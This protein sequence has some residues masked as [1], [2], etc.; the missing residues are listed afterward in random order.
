MNNYSRFYTVAPLLA[1]AK[2][3]EMEATEKKPWMAQGDFETITPLT[4]EYFRWI[5]LNA[6]RL[7]K[8]RKI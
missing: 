5:R 6:K 1:Q 4:T 3:A 2:L 8:L 7:G